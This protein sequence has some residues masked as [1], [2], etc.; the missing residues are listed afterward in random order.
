MQIR[1]LLLTTAAALAAF[2]LQAAPSAQAQ[3]A[4]A[5]QGQVSSAKEGMMEGVVVSARKDGSTITVSVVTD[6]KGHFSFP[7]SRLEPGHYTLATRAIGYDLDGPKAADIA[8]GQAATADI[9][10]KPTK[11][12]TAQMTNAEWLHEHS[13]HRRPEA[14][15]AQL[16]LLPHARAHREIDAR[17]RRV[18]AGVQADG[19]L[20][21][22]QHAAQAAAARRQRGPR[23][24]PG[25]SGTEGGR[26][27]R[28][29]QS[30]PAGKV[31]LAAQDAA[32][33]HRQVDA[34][35]HH[36]IRPAEQTDRAAR[37]HAR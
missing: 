2:V 37:R 33:A 14:L 10:L 4:A 27:A 26:L 35:H 9:K 8:A 23:H 30:Q 16:Q 32:A 22:G 13:R 5:L 29:H 15:P 21:S 18:Q 19:P 20:L 17:R 1:T 6:D 25:R 7:A 11:N 12:L 31:G 24:G 3:N 36:R 28:Q 34:R